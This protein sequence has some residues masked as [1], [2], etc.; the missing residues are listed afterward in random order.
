MKG[1]GVKVGVNVGTTR[2]PCGGGVGRWKTGLWVGSG[3]GITGAG[4][5]SDVGS[6]LGCAVGDSEATTGAEVGASEG[7]GNSTAGDGATVGDSLIGGRVGG[8]GAELGSAVLPP[9]PVGYMFGVLLGL[10]VKKRYVIS[11]ITGVCRLH[12]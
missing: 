4:D 6:E 2:M 10:R 5:G 1:N 3:L 12:L 8:V 11:K 7:S 9:P